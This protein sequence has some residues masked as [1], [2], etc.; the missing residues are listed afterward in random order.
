VTWPVHRVQTYSHTHKA[1]GWVIPPETFTDRKSV[2]ERTRTY[3]QR[4]SGGIT[5]AEASR[6]NPLDTPSKSEALRVA[7]PCAQSRSTVHPVHKRVPGV[8][9]DPGDSRKN[10]LVMLCKPETRHVAHACALGS[11]ILLRSTESIP[12]LVSRS[13]IYPAHNLLWIKE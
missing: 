9:T 2:T 12:G 1:L 6:K 3:S 13:T 11:G 4:V 8:L 5:H 7:H 10:P